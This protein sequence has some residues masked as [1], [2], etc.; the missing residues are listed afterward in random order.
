MHQARKKQRRPLRI[1]QPT[2][3]RHA[4]MTTHA[5]CITIMNC[6]CMLDAIFTNRFQYALYITARAQVSM[7]CCLRSP[8]M[9]ALDSY[10]TGSSVIMHM[11]IGM[12]MHVG[13][14]FAR[15]ALKPLHCEGALLCCWCLVQYAVPCACTG[16]SRWRQPDQYVETCTQSQDLL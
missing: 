5:L 14:H 2:E 7:Q 4:L 9:N 6:C 12:P 10:S 13:V 15:D 16:L 3:H 1:T 8:F 11:C